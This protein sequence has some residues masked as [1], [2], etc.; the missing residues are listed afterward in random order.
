M[1]RLTLSL[2]CA[3]LAPA[4]AAGPVYAADQDFQVW[5]ANTATIDL[6]K[7]WV[8][9]LEAQFRISDNASRLGQT[10]IRPGIG[11]RL[12]PNTTV[13]LGYAYVP[14]D[15]VGPRFLSEHRIWEQLAFRLAGNGKGITL[16]G[17][18]RLE[19]RFVEGTGSMGWRLRQ[20]VRLTA[21][22]TGKVKALVWTEPFIA[23]NDTRWGQRS[24]FDRL[25]TC[26]GLVLPLT[27]NINAEPGYIN[28]WVNR[29]AR[30]RIE[31]IANLTVAAKF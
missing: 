12:D 15:P 7:R 10:L 14:T 22:I 4:V 23:F 31:H 11:Y 1:M 29:S 30:D 9:W 24:G 20:Q 21:P 3:A 16:T 17:R 25:R 8:L 6:D 18:T 27:K 19:Q 5:S 13:T 28:Q 2:A 26:A